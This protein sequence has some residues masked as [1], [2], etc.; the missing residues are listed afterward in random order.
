MVI[1]IIGNEARVTMEHI[2]NKKRRSLTPSKK[3]I[4]EY[5]EEKLEWDLD[6]EECFACGSPIRLER[7]H[8]IPLIFG[9]SNNVDNL[10]VLC[11]VCHSES[12]GL[13]D[14]W[15]WFKYK[16]ENEYMFPSAHLQKRAE[17]TGTLKKINEAAEKY[18][19]Y[20]GGDEYQKHIMRI[21]YEEKWRAHPFEFESGNKINQSE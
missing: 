2:T 7:C 13:K 11:L 3:K 14:Y 1:V 8:I 5:W 12:E 16:R 17:K 20:V 6:D 19:D 18:K 15:Y 9:G 10:Q 21:I 4:L